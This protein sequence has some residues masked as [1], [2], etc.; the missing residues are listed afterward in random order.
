MDS[1]VQNCI[2]AKK[3]NKIEEIISP[4]APFLY[5]PIGSYILYSPFYPGNA[6]PLEIH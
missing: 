6:V 2:F 1:G 4:G 5:W 3:I